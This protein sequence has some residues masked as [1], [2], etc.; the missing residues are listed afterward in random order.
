MTK[1]VKIDIVSHNMLIEEHLRFTFSWRQ[2]QF[3]LSH[4]YP[5]TVS[6]P[7]TMKEYIND[8]DAISQHNGLISRCLI[9]LLIGFSN[10]FIANFGNYNHLCIFIDSMF[11]IK[12]SY[13]LYISSIENFC[14]CCL[15]GE[16]HE[17]CR[18]IAFVSARDFDSTQKFSR[19]I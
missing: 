5:T 18:G 12:L 2:L 9:Y 14:S 19:T 6:N 8:M 4:S 7:S 11:T 3:S 16:H 10:E 1:E 17:S 15:I 13:A